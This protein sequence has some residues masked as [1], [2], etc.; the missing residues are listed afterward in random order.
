MK[1]MKKWQIALLIILA[2]IIIL[3]LIYHKAVW[4]IGMN[5]FQPMIELDESDNWTGGTYD[6]VSYGDLDSQYI[7]L[8][9][10]KTDV[11]APLFVLVHGGGFVSGDSQTR[12][13]QFMYRYFR[14]HGFACAS[15]NYRLAGEAP[16]PAAIEDVGAAVKFLGQHA[17]QYGYNAERVAIWGESAGGYLASYEA[18]SEDEVNIVA[19]V[20]YYGVTDFLSTEEQFK[21]QGIPKFILKIANTWISDSCEGYPSYE[22]YWLRKP[23]ADW[24][25]ERQAASVVWQ[26]EH[27]AKNPALR[28]LIYHGD[29]D[30]TV[31]DAQSALLYNALAHTYGEGNVKLQLF[32]GYMHAADRFYTN[33]Q[34]SEV[35]LFL[36]EVL[37]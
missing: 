32:H 25:E 12:Q 27:N 3:L 17:D 33:Q 23:Y 35:E 18:I 31:P 15:I 30:M 19:L 36:N 8:Y 5:L 21:T 34:L 29:A 16:F 28:S 37:R 2:I 9:V 13:A 4:T 24:T 6:R 7:D 11:P 22:E 10:P 1:T 26:A 14:D 20:D